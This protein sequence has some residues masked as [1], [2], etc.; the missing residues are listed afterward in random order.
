MPSPPPRQLPLFRS[1]IPSDDDDFPLPVPPFAVEALRTRHAA[2]APEGHQPLEE[3]QVPLFMPMAPAESPPSRARKLKTYLEVAE[4]VGLRRLQT[5][6]DLPATCFLFDPVPLQRAWYVHTALEVRERILAH[7]R[8]A[9]EDLAASDDPAIRDASVVLCAGARRASVA[10]STS[11]VMLTI[12]VAFTVVKALDPFLL[13]VE[14][15]QGFLGT[16]TSAPPLEVG[17]ELL[18]IRHGRRVHHLLPV[19]L[20]PLPLSAVLFG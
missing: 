12:I 15:Y 2:E 20:Q 8:G 9:F 11:P 16:T 6:L 17:A 1:G 5:L 10:R 19:E 14:G 4:A 7:L 3:E 18:A 13:R